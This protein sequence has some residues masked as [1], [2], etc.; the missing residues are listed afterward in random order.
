MPP[1]TITPPRPEAETPLV[2]VDTK[3]KLVSLV[4]ELKKEPCI[5]IDLEHHNQHSYQGFTC[6]IQVS[7]R[8]TDY[9][10]DVLVIREHVWL[11]NE[12]TSDPSIMKVLHGANQDI[13]WL[14]KDF[15]VYVVNMFDTGQ[16]A[17]VLG[18]ESFGLAYLL[19]RFCSV[20]ANKEFQR[21]DWRWGSVRVV[22]PRIRPLP[23]I[24]KKYA[25]EDTH[26]LLYICDELRTLL[27]QQ[28][29]ERNL[30]GAGVWGDA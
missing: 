2:E 17:R 22:T 13:L 18:F 5:A 10:V 7:T 24:M 29:G 1:E 12:V 6:L 20:R 23:A 16:A 11:L 8:T 28:S 9:L 27:A 3:E 19:K 26:F 21:A 14:Q 25:R 30:V 15:G 4:E